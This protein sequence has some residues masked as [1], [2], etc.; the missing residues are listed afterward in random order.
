MGVVRVPDSR[1]D[2][3]AEMFQPQKT[4]HA[5]IEYVDTPGSIVDLARTGIQSQ[6]LR[7]LNALVLVVRAFQEGATAE[8]EAQPSATSRTSDWS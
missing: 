2:R 5:T 8:G 7:E 4:T 1:L 3:L 6:T